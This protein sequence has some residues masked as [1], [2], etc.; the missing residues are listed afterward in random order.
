MNCYKCSKKL[1]I[2]KENIIIVQFNKYYV[3]LNKYIDKYSCKN[4]YVGNN[5]FKYLKYDKY[6]KCIYIKY[7]K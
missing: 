1:N 6:K 3:L 7:N 2:K 5:N 4:C